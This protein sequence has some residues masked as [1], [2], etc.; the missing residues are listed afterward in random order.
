MGKSPTS[1]KCDILAS[2]LSLWASE[3]LLALAAQQE[4]AELGYA[5]RSV[6]RPHALDHQALLLREAVHL[7]GLGSLCQSVGLRVQGQAWGCDPWDARFGPHGT[8]RWGRPCP[9]VPPLPPE[10]RE[11]WVRPAGQVLQGSLP[12]LVVSCSFMFFLERKTQRCPRNGPR[13]LTRGRTECCGRAKATPKEA[14]GEVEALGAGAEL[15]PQGDAG[16]RFQGPWNLEARLL[17]HWSSMLPLSPPI[18]KPSSLSVWGPKY[19]SDWTVSPHLQAPSPHL[20][21][22]PGYRPLPQGLW[23]S[24]PL[25]SPCSKP[26]PMRVPS[27]HAAKS[28]P[29]LPPSTTFHGSQLNRKNMNSSWRPQAS[30]QPPGSEPRPTTTT[31]RSP[32]WP[33]A[34][35]T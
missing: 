2:P 32:L 8:L 24:P 25:C 26:R 18:S 3:R 30:A 27:P 28:Y 1:V 31:R 14:G 9:G 33:V 21:P 6:S 16:A 22:R 17:G 34:A 13:E 7:P 35:A 11:G 12:E 10:H 19:L 5:P 23:P 4:G 15:G 20:P 29:V